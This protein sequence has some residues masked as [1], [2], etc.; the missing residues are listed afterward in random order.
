MTEKTKV[1]M[2]TAAA[3]ALEYIKKNPR[4]SHEEIFQHVMRVENAKG[5]A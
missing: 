1:A 4:A 5:E 2:M 3:K